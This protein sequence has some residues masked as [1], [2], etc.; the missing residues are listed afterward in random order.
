MTLVTSGTCRLCGAVKDLTDG[1]MAFFASTMIGDACDLG[2]YNANVGGSE[3]YEL[4]QSGSI[5]W[6]CNDDT[7]CWTTARDSSL[8]HDPRRGR[9]WQEHDQFIADCRATLSGVTGPTLSGMLTMGSH[10]AITQSG[11]DNFED[12]LRASLDLTGNE[13][14][15]AGLDSDDAA[16]CCR[17]LR[18]ECEFP[19]YSGIQGYGEY[20]N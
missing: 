19:T 12:N 5:T 18:N 10:N 11:I 3:T 17:I 14:E 20:Y 6:F 9:I 16:L 1:S 7:A 4:T 15:D 13:W 8:W 2:M